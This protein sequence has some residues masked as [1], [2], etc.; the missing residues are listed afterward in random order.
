MRNPDRFKWI[1]R[2]PGLLYGYEEA[3]GYC[4]APELVQDKDG[5]S[6]AVLIAELAAAAKADGRTF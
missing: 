5:I 4:V 1:S 6:A 3:L 2:V